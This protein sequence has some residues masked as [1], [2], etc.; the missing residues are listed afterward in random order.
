MMYGWG[1]WIVMTLV[2]VLVWAA[3]ITAIVAAIHYLT[4]S[5]SQRNQR[6]DRPTRSADGVLAERFARG[7]IDENEYRRRA[8]LLREHRGA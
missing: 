2:M 7:D 6:S 1:A 8:T 3:V 4:G 5:G